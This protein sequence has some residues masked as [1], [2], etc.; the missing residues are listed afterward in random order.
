MKA[1]TAQRLQQVMAERNLRQVD[2]LNLSKKYQEELG[3]SMSKSSLSEYL[4]GSSTPDQ[5]KL[6]L[7]GKTL[8]VSEAWLMGYNVPR[9]EP[10]NIIL[11]DNNSMNTIGNNTYNFTPDSDQTDH[12]TTMQNLSTADLKLQRSLLNK[13]DENNILL[14]SILDAQEE[15]NQLQKET[16]RLLENLLNQ[17]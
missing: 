3:I 10:K 5:H 12:N 2:V 11:G 1:S 13:I 7:L 4:S 14:R 16:N 9:V 17:K 6:T 15:G 8:G